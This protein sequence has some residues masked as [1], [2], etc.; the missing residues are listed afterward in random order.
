V[1]TALAGTAIPNQPLSILAATPVTAV[2]SL[3]YLRDPN[4]ADAAIQAGLTTALVD[5][6]LGLLGAANTGI[7]RPVYDSQIAAACLAVPG[8]AAIHDV[9][10]TTEGGRFFYPIIITGG[11]L[12]RVGGATTTTG[13]TGNRHSP[14]AG[15]YFSVPNDPQH[16]I[17][18]GVL[19][20]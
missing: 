8:V 7:G 1:Q 3:T 5:P 4:I 13:C 12:R 15:K 16:L 10:L 6:V 18:S 19:A 17:L 9:S 14:G 2:L 20:S 11:R